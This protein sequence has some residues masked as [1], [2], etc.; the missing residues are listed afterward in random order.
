MATS[1]TAAIGMLAS[2]TSAPRSTAKPPNISTKIVSHPMRCGAGTPSACR[3]AGNASGP[4]ASL[5]KPC[6][7]K[8]YPTISR[9]GIGA[10]RASGDLL[11]RSIGRSRHLGN[12]QCIWFVEWIPMI[13]VPTKDFVSPLNTLLQWF[14][15]LSR[16]LKEVADLGRDLSAM[17]LKRKVSGVEKA[18]DRPRY[19]PFERFGSDR[20]KERIVLPPRR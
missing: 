10:Q 20:Q 13:S 15:L 4:L 7:M 5:A 17:S 1:R 12:C 19:V 2:G 11:I 18:D 14:L 3:I 9:S 8:P 6:S 16:D